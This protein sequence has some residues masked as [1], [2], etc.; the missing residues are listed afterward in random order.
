[1]KLGTR[2]SQNYGYLVNGCSSE[3]GL[4]LWGL[5]LPKSGHRL[6]WSVG[7][8]RQ[9]HIR[10]HLLQLLSLGFGSGCLSLMEGGV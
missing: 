1:M 6:C 4:N 10:G 8:V 9:M 5:E 2:V 3:G 7:F